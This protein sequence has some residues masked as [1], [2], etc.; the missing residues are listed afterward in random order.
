MAAPLV[1]LMANTKNF[2]KES[3]TGLDAL[4]N[5]W[6]KAR[7]IQWTE[8]HEEGVKRKTMDKKGGTGADER[9]SGFKGKSIAKRRIHLQN[10]KTFIQV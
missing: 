5:V 3:V 8:K 1:L 10:W 6:V 4:K 9:H 7:L 2:D